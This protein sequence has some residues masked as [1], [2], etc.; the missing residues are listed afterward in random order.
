MAKCLIVPQ[1]PDPIIS[2][3]PQKTL[4]KD[5]EPESPSFSYKSNCFCMCSTLQFTVLSSCGSPCDAVERQSGF[6][7]LLILWMGKLVPQKVCNLSRV[8]P[9][10]SAL[11]LLERTST[12]PRKCGQRGKEEQEP[13][14]ETESL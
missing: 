8:G 1:G 2:P 10:P 9:S 5:P 6:F 11:G 12:N 14:I 7:V 4:Q 13:L 3:T